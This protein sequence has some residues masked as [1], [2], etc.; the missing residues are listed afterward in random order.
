MTANVQA[1]RI[2]ANGR[3][4]FSTD[5]LDVPGLD[6]GAPFSSAARESVVPVVEGP[7]ANASAVWSPASGR[8]RERARGG[9]I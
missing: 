6:S 4:R 8:A 7:T 2:L 5:D 9:L 1:G 3:A